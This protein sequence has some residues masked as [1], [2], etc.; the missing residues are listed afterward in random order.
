MKRN[1]NLIL[2][3]TAVAVAFAAG[4]LTLIGAASPA[5]ASEPAKA[6][7]ITPEIQAC[8]TAGT[9][10]AQHEQLEVLAGDWDVSV[11]MW[12]QAGAEPMACTAKLRREWVLDKR[13]LRETVESTSEWGTFQGIG[14][15]GYS[16]IDG[17]YQSIWLDNMSTAIVSGTGSFDASSK[18]LSFR[19]S[20]RDPMTGA[21][22]STRGTL[23]VSN[24]DR[25]VSAEFVTG[26]DGK[27]F[28]AFEGIAQRVK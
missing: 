9:P 12:Q 28:L 26:A 15:L 21:V 27:E 8:I 2:T 11:R 13:F 10:G 14:Y 1:G 7:E 17:Q 18:V 6:A 24:P 16:N 5:N 4:R 20:H 22:R 3:G 25:H 23:D 19:G